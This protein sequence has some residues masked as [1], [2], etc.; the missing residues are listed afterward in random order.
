MIDFDALGGLGRIKMVIEHSHEFADVDVD[1]WQATDLACE[2]LGINNLDIIEEYAELA[3]LY[4][5]VS[6]TGWSLYQSTP[7]LLEFMEYMKIK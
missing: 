1:A 2:D 7:Q 5:V 6:N 4:H 3:N